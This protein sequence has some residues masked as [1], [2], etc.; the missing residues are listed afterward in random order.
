MRWCQWILNTILRMRSL[1]YDLQWFVF[2]HMIYCDCCCTT[3]ICNRYICT[4]FII[5][6]PFC[7]CKSKKK[8]FFFFENN[9]VDKC[10]QYSSNI[11]TFKW[12][13]FLLFLIVFSYICMHTAYNSNLMIFR[14]VL[15]SK[16]NSIIFSFLEIFCSYLAFTKLIH[17]SFSFA[18]AF[19]SLPPRTHFTDA[20]QL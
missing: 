11:N 1:E 13:L 7:R 19:H 9:E 12:K 15:I 2:V 16:W 8:V 10:C 17:I 20:F 6:Y 5:N 3:M 14:V 18:F 4:Y